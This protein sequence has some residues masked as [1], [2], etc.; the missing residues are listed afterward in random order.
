MAVTAAIK[1][2]VFFIF[3]PLKASC[4]MM[5]VVQK[6]ALITKG[7]LERALFGR[8]L[9]AQAIA[10]ASRADALAEAG[11][12]AWRV[13]RFAAGPSTAHSCAILP[14]LSRQRRA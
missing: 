14:A 13:S 6:V 9:L 3:L 11:N 8:L 1:D 2:I 12:H 7:D 5:K 10:V 4:E